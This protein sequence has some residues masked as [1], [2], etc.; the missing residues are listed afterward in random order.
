MNGSLWFASSD[1]GW[2]GL[3]GLIDGSGLMGLTEDLPVL[4][5]RST[6][7]CWPVS[8][9][10]STTFTHFYFCFSPP[11]GCSC[12][13]SHQSPDSNSHPSKFP[14]LLGETEGNRWSPYAEAS[15]QLA[16][17]LASHHLPLHLFP[18]D[19][20]DLSACTFVPLI[21][22]QSGRPHLTP[23]PSPPHPCG[24][25]YRRLSQGLKSHQTVPDV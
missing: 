23:H 17:A 5:L 7:Q 13:R 25:F 15:L 6:S 24:V 3:V 1:L 9:A 10:D 21:F 22:L 12:H 16:A 4:P 11:T 8:D 18:Y 19:A 2:V 20:S 14:R